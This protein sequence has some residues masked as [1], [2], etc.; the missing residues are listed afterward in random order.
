[1]NLLKSVFLGIVVIA[2][3]ST[4]ACIN[5]SEVAEGN[6]T[7]AVVVEKSI[8]N[9]PVE[10]TNDA[11]ND[12]AFDESTEDAI[13]KSDIV[14][15]DDQKKVTKTKAVSHADK[16]TDVSD[17]EPVEK[18]EDVVLSESLDLKTKRNV[19][20]NPDNANAPVE[21][22]EKSSI[23]L[24]PIFSDD[25]LGKYY[26]QFKESPSKM[27]KKDVEAL[28]KNNH[29]VY[30]VSHQGLYKYCVG[31]SNSEAEAKAFQKEFIK[32]HSKSKTTVVTYKSAW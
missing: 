1:M 25:D 20:Y 21:I 30:V 22:E 19:K 28:L 11:N 8:D 9:A 27:S 7:D 4:T 2:I 14:E 5:D 26:V 18:K 12:A 3:G 16:K 31:K 13:V 17:E 24:V 23:T 15:V 6:A 32:L 10:S 29:K